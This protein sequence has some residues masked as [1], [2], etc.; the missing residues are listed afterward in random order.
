MHKY[1]QFIHKLPHKSTFYPQASFAKLC[2]AQLFFIFDIKKSAC[3]FYASGFYFQKSFLCRFFCSTSKTQDL[4]QKFTQFFYKNFYPKKTAPCWS[5]ARIDLHS[6]QRNRP[7]LV[8]L[9]RF[10]QTGQLKI[11]GKTLSST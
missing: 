5:I 3:S 11:F 7:L 9:R 10:E 1:P 4:T 6:E 8:A 2:F